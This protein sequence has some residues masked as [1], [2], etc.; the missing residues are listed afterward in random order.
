MLCGICLRFNLLGGDVFGRVSDKG[1]S[2]DREQP[3][4]FQTAEALGRFHHAGR[5]PAE[6]HGSI[7]PSLTLRQTRRNVPIMFSIELVQASDR[8]SF[9]GSFR[10]LTVSISSRPSRMLAATPGA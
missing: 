6:R 5:R 3:V 7:S 9:A 4:G 1:S 2:E 10:R 8:R